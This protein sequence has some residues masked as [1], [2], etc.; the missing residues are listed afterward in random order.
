[1][2]VHSLEGATVLLVEDEFM[3]ALEIADALE[4]VG[5]QVSGPHAT[6]DAAR[7]AA[8]TANADVAILDIDLR[9]EEVFPVAEALRER[10]IPFVFYTGR[11]DREALRTCFA[12][13]PVFVKPAS[14]RYLL[15]ELGKLLP[16]AA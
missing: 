5:A 10:G 4:S 15:T 2:A 1:M 14:T 6:L 11:P 9:G 13:I 16:I 3:I 12:D 7:K 8:S